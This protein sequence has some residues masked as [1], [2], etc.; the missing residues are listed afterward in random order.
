VA[1]LWFV[2]KRLAGGLVTLLLVSVLIFVLL[3]F[4]PGNVA[5]KQLGPWASQASKDILFK[6]LKLDDPLLLR[7]G[8]WLGILS[9][10]IKDPLAATDLGFADPRG[11]RYFGNFGYSQFYKIPVNDIIWGRLGNTAILGA[12]AF[13]VIVPLSILI[14]VVAG[15][16]QGRFVDRWLSIVSVSLTAVPEFASAV[17]LMTIFVVWLGWAPGTSNLE[18][19]GGWSFASQLVLPATVLV[20]YATGYIARIVRNSMASVM[21]TPYVRTAILKGLSFRTVILVHAL[22]NALIAPFTV[23]LL[24]ISWLLSGVVVTEVVFGYP[25]FGRM[26]YEA[27]MFG[28]VALLEAATLVALLIASATQLASDLAYRF[29]NPR[30]QLE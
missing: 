14:G 22:R 25:G 8:R 1:M 24:Q 2:A 15:V 17:I 9:G 11:A 12:V 28:D 23:I 6:E 4:T 27:A 13:L 10:I 18:T 30:I 5:H 3:E 21:G 29:L 26:L 7:Y 16:Y 20:L 19:G